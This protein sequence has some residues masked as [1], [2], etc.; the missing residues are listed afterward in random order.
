MVLP[1]QSLELSGASE[2][3]GALSA[4]KKFLLMLPGQKC[5]P[6]FPSKSMAAPSKFSLLLLFPLP[7]SDPPYFYFIGEEIFTQRFY[8]LLKSYG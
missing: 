5:F 1:Q 2:T 6:G 7:L 4:L 8:D 3:S